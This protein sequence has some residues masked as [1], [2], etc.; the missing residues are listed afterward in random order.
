[1]TVLVARVAPFATVAAVA[2][3]PLAV[4]VYLLAS[5]TWSLAEQ[6]ALGRIVG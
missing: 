4:S 3:V 2:V 5:S 1:V 6:A